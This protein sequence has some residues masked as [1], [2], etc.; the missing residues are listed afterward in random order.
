MSAKGLFDAE[1]TRNMGKNPKAVQ[2]LSG[3]DEFSASFLPFCFQNSLQ[4][5]VLGFWSSSHFFFETELQ[6]PE[7][8]KQKKNHFF[9]RFAHFLPKTWFLLLD[10]FL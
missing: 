6:F 8:I 1:K 4:N 3:N 9:L 5:G 10:S 7:K 2:K